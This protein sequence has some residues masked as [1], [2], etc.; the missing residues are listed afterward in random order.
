M[1]RIFYISAFVFLGLLL[2]FLVHAL[3]EIWYINLLLKDF[4]Y[5]GFGWPWDTWYTIHDVGTWVLVVLGLVFGYSQ[6]K[7]W[8]PKLYNE[9]GK[10]KKQRYV[11]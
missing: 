1:K 5:Y 10:L 2:Q 9:Q 3:V 6:G 4:A 8:W 7:H 11:C